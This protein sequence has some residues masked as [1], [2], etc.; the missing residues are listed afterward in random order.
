MFC[1]LHNCSQVAGASSIR[2]SGAR[3]GIIMLRAQMCE[4][5]AQGGLLISQPTGASHQS[6]SQ[7]KQLHSRDTFGPK[8][9]G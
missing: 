4:V 9:L 2:R 1:Y 7:C 6:E 5:W 8:H 3:R